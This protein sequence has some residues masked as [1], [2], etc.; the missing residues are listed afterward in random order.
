MDHISNE[1]PPKRRRLDEDDDTHDKELPRGLERPIS[2]PP[3]KRARGPGPT[4]I[5]SP[6]HLTSIQDLPPSSN[7]DTISL[8]DIL[9]DPLISECWEFNYLHN[10]DFLMDAFDEDVKDIVKV[11]IIHGFWKHEDQSRLNLKEQASKYPNVN[12]LTAYMPEMFGTHHTKMMI[13]LR[14]DSTAQVIIHTANMIPFD[15]TNM[16]QAVWKSPLLPLIDP[17]KPSIPQSTKIGSGSRFKT[18]FL[19]YLNAY[20]TRRVICK[21]LIESLSKYDFSEVRGALIGSVPG[22]Q[23]IDPDGKTKWG[24][25]GLSNALKS[26]PTSKS[27]AEIA[28]QISSI[29]SLGATD[30]WLKNTFFQALTDEIRRS[31]NGYQSGNAIHT[32][33]LTPTQGKQLAYLKPMLCHWAGD[34]GQHAAEAI[35]TPTLDAGRKRA[36]PH[37]KTYL[38]FGDSSHTEIDWM[39]VTS[40]NL[41]KQAWGEATNAAGE[42]RVCSYEIGVLVW[43]ELFGD[44][45][46]MVPTF[47]TDSPGPGDA[48][49]GDA[50]ILVGARM[51]Y[52]LPIVPYA[53][54]DMPWCASAVYTEPDWMGQTWKE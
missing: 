7:A 21:P 24:W 29:A 46:K 13:L 17:S 6:F 11:N 39:L 25:L 52:D 1:G 12:L 37:I 42:V 3:T 4:V 38:R 36:A 31:L 53:R 41:S 51:P 9:G 19:N 54:N 16:T 18:D 26:I 43:P 10:I 48:G 22:K 15:W 35:E 30:K 33:I 5:D 32:K 44:D 14:H 23:D 8:K 40:A 27:K 34:G 20:D 49:K 45:A 47:K 50:K 2:P 28:I